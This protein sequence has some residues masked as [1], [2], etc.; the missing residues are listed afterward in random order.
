MIPTTCP[1]IQPVPAALPPTMRAVRCTT[2]GGPEVMEIV[3]L[4]LP[5]PGPGQ[6]LIRVHAAGVNRPDLSQ[7]RGTY[8]VPA[9]AD[10]TLGL[11][12]A[13][14]IVSV[15]E[16]VALS[17]GAR[18]CSLVHGGGYADYALGEADHVIPLPE[19]LDFVAG[20]T[21]PEVAMTVELNLIERALLR[22]GEWALIHGGSSGIG[23]HAIQRA[24]AMGARVIV[25]AGSAEKCAY[26]LSL[27]ADVAINYRAADFLPA[28]LKTT[29]GR[30][31]DVILDMVGGDYVDRNLRALAPDG[32]CAVISLQQG[33]RVEVDLDPLLRRRLTLTGS[34]L[35]P[36][37]KPEKAAL[38][39]RVAERV[40]PLVV[41]GRI[42][43][44]IA[45][46][47]PLEEVR[48]AHRLL[49][50]GQSMGKIALTLTRP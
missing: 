24:K 7:R 28:V 44:S 8:P 29:R 22:A 21:L 46:V 2:A 5:R 31:V 35:R 9:D 10:P 38:A 4:P 41:D 30:G 42:R 50:S 37:P 12:V 32:R 34:T 16:G 49:E 20:A 43:G 45:R 47:F 18:V 19:A 36:L 1:Q 17:P 3:A 23:S 11:E 27:G 40:L 13:G 15:G 26:C 14:V 33:P 6:V 25:T 48:A 39:R